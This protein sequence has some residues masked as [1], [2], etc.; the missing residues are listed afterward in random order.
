M[1]INAASLQTDLTV[2]TRS[3]DR[4]GPLSRI[5]FPANGATVSG[6]VKVT[7]TATD[8]GGA[9]AGVEVSVDGGRTW[10]PAQGTDAWSYAWQVPPGSGTATLMTRATDDSVNVE[11]PKSR[12]TVRIGTTTAARR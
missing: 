8:A 11:T 4:S 7:G 1:G 10:H 6:L 2:P 9:V 5:A 12:V 3:T